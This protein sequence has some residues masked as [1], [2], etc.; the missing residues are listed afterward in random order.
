MPTRVRRRLPSPW[1]LS[2]AL[3]RLV[4]LIEVPFGQILVA[5]EMIGAQGFTDAVLFTEP[6]AEVDHLAAGG[7]KRPEG[8]GE[9]IILPAADR[10]GDER[11]FC[12]ATLYAKASEFH[13]ASRVGA[14]LSASRAARVFTRAE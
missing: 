5:G 2:K 4:G 1:L 13:R 14:S 3:M 11:A 12:H 8:I 10:T 9:V 7:A 6:F